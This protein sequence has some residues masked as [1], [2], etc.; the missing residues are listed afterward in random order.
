MTTQRAKQKITSTK[1]SK[2]SIE[3]QANPQQAAAIAHKDGPAAFIAAAGT[4]KTSILVQR[5]VRLVAD[6]GI[7]PESIL[8][9]TFTRAAANEMEKRALK[10][11]KARG[12]VA[13]DVKALRVVTFHGLGHQI[14]R[15]KL[16]W[17]PQELNQRLVSGEPRQWLAEDILRPWRS[18][19]TRGMNWDVEILDVLSAIDRAKEAMIGPEHSRTFFASAVGIDGELAERY[20]EIYQHYEQS[21]QNEKLYDLSDLIYSPL[22]LLQTS[23]TSRKTWHGRS[24]HLHPDETQHNNPSHHQPN[25]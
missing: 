10:A 21:K 23:P 4:G 3:F 12:M 11:L 22:N 1:L 9:V 2:T 19:R 13:K 5:L 20:T 16:Q 24:Q 17:T 14:L 6:E 18:N 8:C 7:A 25:Q 15:E